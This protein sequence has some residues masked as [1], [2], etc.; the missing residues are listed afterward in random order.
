MLVA[1]KVLLWDGLVSNGETILVVRISEELK[2]IKIAGGSLAPL[3]KAVKI[4]WGDGTKD[5]LSDFLG[6]MHT[7]DR[8]GEYVIT[9]S[10][11][12]SSFG[13][14]SDIE[15]DEVYRPML[16]ELVSIG[17]KVTRIEDY[18]FNN[19]KNMRGRISLPNVTDISWHAFGSTEGITEFILPSITRLVQESFFTMPSAS[20]LYAD[21]V[22]EIDSRFF[23]YYGGNLKDL[24]IRNL[25]RFEIKDIDGFPFEASGDVRFHG[26]D[27]IILA[28]GQLV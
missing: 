9:I 28:N 20:R 14:T 13:F 7:Y 16:I 2:T 27:G 1:S 23:E 5:V 6:R 4:S 21:N 25:S 3:S 24:Y 19:C 11:D 17:S 10:D 8:S 18:A 12:I 15:G 26:S 22:V